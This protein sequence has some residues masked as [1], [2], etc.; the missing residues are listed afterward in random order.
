VFLVWPL[1]LPADWRLDNLGLQVLGAVLLVVV[2]GYLG[3]CFVAG[4]RVWHLRGQTL[5]LP[6]GRMAVL[7]LLVA[8]TNWLLIGAVVYTLLQF[9]VDYPT[10]LSAMLLAS[11]AG[12]VTHIPAGLGVLEAVFVA[13]LSGRM[14]QGELLAALLAYRVIYYLAPL[15]VAG[16]LYFVVSARARRADAAAAANSPPGA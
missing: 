4:Q 5:D 10:V 1:V 16:I 11:V 7:Q 3:W 9:R 15:V 14:A 8:S 13:L 2:A 12:L 6:S